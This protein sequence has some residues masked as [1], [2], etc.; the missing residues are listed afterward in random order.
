MDSDGV[1]DGRSADMAG[2]G[3]DFDVRGVAD[4]DGTGVFP[5]E[6]GR[7]SDEVDEVISSVGRGDRAA[8][9]MFVRVSM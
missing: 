8:L 5:A 1:S 7:S 9:F 4:G 6:E 3:L 2:V